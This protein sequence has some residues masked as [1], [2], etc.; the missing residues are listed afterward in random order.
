M[1]HIAENDGY[2]RTMN[3][4]VTSSG[5]T[6]TIPV[7]QGSKYTNQYTLDYAPSDIMFESSGGTISVTIRSD[8]DWTITEGYAIEINQEQNEI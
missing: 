3:I 1:V 6:I 8:S 7:S 2:A 5:Q 4:N